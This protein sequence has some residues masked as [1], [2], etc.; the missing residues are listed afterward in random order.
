MYRKA[1]AETGDQRFEV[2]ENPFIAVRYGIVSMSTLILTSVS[3]GTPLKFR[4][5]PRIPVQVQ[6]IIS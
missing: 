1:I 4:F 6:D 2:H 3:A 5:S